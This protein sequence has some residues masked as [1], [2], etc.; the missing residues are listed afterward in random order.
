M[1]VTRKLSSVIVIC[2]LT[3]AA[4][5]GSDGSGN[6]S[7][8]AP[9]PPVPFTVTDIEVGTGDEAVSGRSIAVN[10]VGWLYDPARPGNRGAQFDSS[11]GVGPYVFT[12]GAGQVIRG[13]DQG[14][15]GMRV[16][17]VRHLVIPPA[18]AYGSSGNGPIP[19]NA[20]LIFQVEL[21]SV[22]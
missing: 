19:P 22:S 14:L 9:T 3:L 4:C 5:G 1:T 20:T 12:L 13:W 11:A 17:G 16:G 2:A 6:G 8:T 7:P 21:V 15:A 18:L 10:Y